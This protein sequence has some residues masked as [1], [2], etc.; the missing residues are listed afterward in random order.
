MH[1]SWPIHFVAQRTAHARACFRMQRQGNVSWVISCNFHA[2]CGWIFIPAAAR[3]ESISV[4]A[5]VLPRLCLILLVEENTAKSSTWLYWHKQI[6]KKQIEF[7]WTCA[8]RDAK[9]I[10]NFVKQSKE[11]FTFMSFIRR[12]VAWAYVAHQLFTLTIK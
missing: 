6:E 1:G 9:R 3:T 2:G 11:E 5:R 7:W 4:L 8:K 10:Y 12:A